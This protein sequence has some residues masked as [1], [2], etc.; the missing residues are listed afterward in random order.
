MSKIKI[1]NFGPIGKGFPDND[2]FIE[3]KKVT[4]FIGNQGSGKSTIAKLISTM[5]WIEKAL[6]RGDFDT[7]TVDQF[8]EHCFYQ[9][10]GN[11]FKD[12]SIIEYEGSAYAIA[13]SSE[14]VL[15][16]KNLLNGYVFPKIMYVPAERN[17][18]SSVRNVG[19]LK[20]LPRTLYTFSDEYFRAL[21][22]ITGLKE[23]PINSAKLE[24]DR[25]TKTVYIQ[26]PGDYSIKLS[27]ASSGFQSFVPLFLV[28][29]YLGDTLGRK[30]NNA[31]NSSSIE[32]EARLRKRIQEI[33]SN[34][35]LTDEVKKA[36]LEV[37]SSETK[38]GAFI[39]IVEEPEQNLFPTSQREVLNS[40]LA[41][42]NQN[43][44][45]ILILTTHSPYLINYLTLAVKAGS[46]KEKINT[47]S[48][49]K[50][51]NSIVPINSSLTTNDLVVYELNDNKGVISK[52]KDHKGMPSDDNELNYELG[53]TN[54]YFAKLL[55][56]QQLV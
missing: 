55:E 7:L 34:P 50:K 28:T 6:V 17:L 19:E 56:I 24:Y 26:E 14:K 54:E 40:L 44:N 48:L 21:D 41:F 27:E 53:E 15:I 32:E 37:I 51:L 2:G 30:K 8:K 46:L 33:M 5:T 23:I 12:D 11:Y 20:G 49:K 18:V 1:K 3:I 36:S 10:I 45:N 35:N 9:N 22:D 38:Y 29:G 42:N 47:D 13:Y 31:I 25:L 4:V 39:N 52:L 43:K 16:T